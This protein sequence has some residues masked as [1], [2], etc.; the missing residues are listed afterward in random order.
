MSENENRAWPSPLLVKLSRLFYEEIKN[1]CPTPMDLPWDDLREDDRMAYV[2]A[3]EVVLKTY[4]AE[5][6]LPLRGL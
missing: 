2:F 6:G 1:D 4:S 3:I 5:T